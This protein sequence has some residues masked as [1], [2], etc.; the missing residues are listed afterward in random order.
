[1]T[2]LRAHSRRPLAVKAA[3]AL[4]A[5]LALVAPPAASAA[6]ACD[7]GHAMPA[8]AGERKVVRATLCLLNAERT[9]QRLTP[10]RLDRRLSKAADR[11]AGDMVRHRFFSHTSLDGSSFLDRIRSTGYL[12]KAGAWSAGENIAWG[13][14]SRS[15]PRSIAQAWMQSPGHR[16]N[17][18]SAEFRDIGIGVA[19][20]APLTGFGGTAGTYTTDFGSRR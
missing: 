17:I 2:H 11:H 9:R 5:A 19:A 14:G 15:T 18:L 6:R 1:V 7:S 4:A 8:S 3:A 20:G 13:S 10:L 16:A 12:R